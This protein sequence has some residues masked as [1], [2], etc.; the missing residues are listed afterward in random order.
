M[1][2]E[3]AFQGGSMGEVSGAKLT[4]ALDLARADSEKGI[5][6]AAVHVARDRRCASSGGQSRTG[7]HRRNHGVHSRPRS[8]A[9]VIS[10]IAGTVGCFGGMSLAAGLSSYIV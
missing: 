7:G 5:P 6:T 9:P 10:V 2:L 8:Y 3:G 1:A 4:A